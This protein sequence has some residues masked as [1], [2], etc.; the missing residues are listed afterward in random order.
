[1]SILRVPHRNFLPLAVTIV[2]VAGTSAA[3]YA[4]RTAERATANELFAAESESILG[5]LHDR[6]V[7]HDRLLTAAW[8]FMNASES[9]TDAEW[10]AWCSALELHERLPELVALGRWQEAGRSRLVTVYHHAGS[11]PVERA[12]QES[13]DTG[14]AESG[15]ILLRGEPGKILFLSTRGA[16]SGETIG[17]WSVVDARV[18][19][20]QVFR[21]V[22]PG[23]EL[24]LFAQGK[25]GRISL[26]DT[27]G[28][29]AGRTRGAET[30]LKREEFVVAGM[31]DSIRVAIAARA[32][33]Y[34]PP[35]SSQQ[36][37]IMMGGALLLLL[38]LE[39]TQRLTRAHRRAESVAV[40]RSA[41]VTAMRSLIERT[42]DWVWA[43]DIDGRVLYSNAAVRQMLGYEAEELLGKVAFRYMHPDDLACM[44]SDRAESIATGGW[45]RRQVRWIHRDGSVRHFESSG[46]PVHD[47][48]GNAI[49]IQG[50]ERDVTARVVA[51]EEVARNERRFRA[52][53]ERG[54]E[55]VALVDSD[56][57]IGYVTPTVQ[58]VCGHA[59]ASLAGASLLD[60]V[61][62]EDR[63]RAEAAFTRAIREPRGPHTVAMR[64]RHS[65]GEWRDVDTSMTNHLADE[66]VQAI[67]V[68]CRDVTDRLEL[69][70]RLSRMANM[71]SLG[72]VAARITHEFN[73][74]LMSIG[75]LAELLRRKA[76]DAQF[77]V[78]TA[79]R[80]TQAIQRGSAI[81]R[82]IT[83]YTN[84]TQGTFEE[85][86]LAEWLAGITRDLRPL[87]GAGVMLSVND[88]L[89][90]LRVRADKEQLTQVASNLIINARDAMPRGGEI[91]I[92]A[93][94]AGRA[95][96]ARAGLDDQTTF[97]HLEVRDN[98]PGMPESVRVK[99][100]EPF[101]TT[102]PRGSGI[103][104]AVVQKII[105][106]HGG[107]VILESEPG[108]G[109]RF[110]LF[111]PAWGEGWH[112]D[113]DQP[114]RQ[115]SDLQ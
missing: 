21:D 71:D 45:T 49:A 7:R 5:V 100:F 80:L 105:L 91:E 42:S 54:A 67:V 93:R 84:P 62:P 37:V 10:D 27:E 40:R 85:V 46:I 68:N 55:V 101:F 17:I 39:L 14:P 24:E 75:P 88:D 25:N 78:S 56:L 89:D 95:E 32:G 41:E 58:N 60:F 20:G 94:R 106:A 109:S 6:L 29:G 104:L 1:M 15:R 19:A 86:S 112:G 35:V 73:N 103:G 52:M 74:V 65:R 53:V 8:A 72:R 23:I 64:V 77:V 96:V 31:G 69:E 114:A 99:A 16:S 110:H 18:L 28:A 2:V 59:E 113:A 22:P 34:G 76:G 50:I 11:A 57:R 81:T 43:A 92:T 111:I 12:V 9:V 87:L 98:G 61:H 33:F 97:V 30:V 83:Q 63:G 115:D 90:G 82:E 13:F 47:E 66:A 4:I 26:F 108:R 107:R 38:G 79:E 48:Q 3:L 36:Q 70:R 102:K 51:A 44:L